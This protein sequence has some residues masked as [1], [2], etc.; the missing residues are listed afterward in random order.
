MVQLL[1]THNVRMAFPKGALTLGSRYAAERRLCLPDASLARDYPL[2]LVT[3]T[4]DHPNDDMFWIAQAKGA[5]PGREQAVRVARRFRSAA[6]GKRILQCGVRNP[7]SAGLG[8]G[9]MGRSI[10]L[11]TV[12]DAW[13]LMKR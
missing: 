11:R 13:M 12:P 4:V 2:R 6:K 1:R 8:K 7:G 9:H 10:T 3:G 5:A